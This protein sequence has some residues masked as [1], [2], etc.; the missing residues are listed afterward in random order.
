MIL[1]RDLR[2]GFYASVPQRPQDINNTQDRLNTLRTDKWL[3]IRS[4]RHVGNPQ[5]PWISPDRLGIEKIMRRGD[6]IV[7]R[8]GAFYGIQHCRA[9]PDSPREN[10]LHGS[11]WIPPRGAS[12]NPKSR[13]LEADYTTHGCRYADGTTTITAVSHRHGPSSHKRRATAARTARRLAQIPR[14]F[15]GPMP[16]SLS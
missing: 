13:G 8:V 1:L 16:E 9:I 5:L 2:I 7:A 12:G 3:P 14:I 15:G 6:A 4:A 11:S 10:K